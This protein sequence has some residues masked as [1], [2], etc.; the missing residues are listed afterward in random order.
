MDIF[1]FEFLPELGSDFA[2][3]KVELLVGCKD[4]ELPPN[5]GCVGVCLAPPNMLLDGVA[6]DAALNID[7][8]P[9]DDACEEAPNKLDPTLAAVVVV[10]PIQNEAKRSFNYFKYSFFVS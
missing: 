8:L 1:S 3:N 2:P 10:E 9:L 4:C 5:T 7:L 6:F